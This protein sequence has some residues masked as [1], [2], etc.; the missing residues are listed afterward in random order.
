MSNTKIVEGEDPRQMK[1]A[2]VDV[3]LRGAGARRPAEV[4]ARLLGIVGL[5]VLALEVQGRDASA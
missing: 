5:R 4:L 3:L 2:D 1:L